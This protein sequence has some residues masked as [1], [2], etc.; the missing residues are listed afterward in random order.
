MRRRIVRP[1]VLRRRHQRISRSSG[2]GGMV[3]VQVRAFGL[4][5]LVGGQSAV[6]VSGPVGGSPSR[7]PVSWGVV[8]LK[9]P[10]VLRTF[11]SRTDGY[12]RIPDNPGRA[13]R[14]RGLVWMRN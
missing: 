4:G 14:D 11:L 3:K 13:L 6:T 1:T 7:W 12:P 5:H 8:V 10:S 2:P 9:A